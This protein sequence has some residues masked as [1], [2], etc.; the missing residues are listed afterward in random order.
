LDHH[1]NERDQQRLLTAFEPRKQLR[2]EAAVPNTRDCQEQLA[3]PRRQQALARAVPVALSIAGALIPLSSQ[4]LGD[5][6]LEHLVDDL[7]EQSADPVVV[8]KKLLHEV[9]IN[10]KL[11]VGRPSLQ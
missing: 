1:L 7:L 11:I 2:R 5:V 4:V 9:A 6:R 10:G 8:Q 3:D